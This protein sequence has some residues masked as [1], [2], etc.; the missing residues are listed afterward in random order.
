[1]MKHIK[2]CLYSNKNVMKQFLIPLK[3][4][5]GAVRCTSKLFVADAPMK[6]KIKKIENFVL[7][8]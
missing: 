2:L 8:Q 7:G 1:M 5:G 3:H 6:E 4:G